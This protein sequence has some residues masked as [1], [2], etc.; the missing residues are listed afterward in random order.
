MHKHALCL[1]ERLVYE[2]EYFLSRLVLAV[3]EYLRGRRCVI[4]IWKETYLVFLIDPVVRQVG[5]SDGLPMVRNLP[6]CAVDNSRDL[7]RDNKLEV[8]YTCKQLRR[9]Y[10]CCEF[11]TDKEAVFN[12]D[13]ADDV[14]FGHL[15]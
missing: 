6:T 15:N 10:L 4:L 11:V 14:V 9:A 5:N 8:L 1:L 13:C 2:T 3:K 12:F 7:V